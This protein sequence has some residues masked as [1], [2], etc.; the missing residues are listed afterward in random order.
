MPAADQ[1]RESAP[2]PMEASPPKTPPGDPLAHALA[3][4]AGKLG[5]PDFPKGDLADLRRGDRGGPPPPAFWR[6]YLDI[7]ADQ[8]GAWARDEKS[9]RTILQCMAIMAPKAHNP[10]RRLGRVLAELM[11][12]GQ[13][14]SLETRLLKLL[15]S[16][17]R[18]LQEQIRHTARLLASRER[19]VDWTQ[20]ARLVLLDADRRSETVRRDMARDFYIAER[21]N[22][23]EL[24]GPDTPETQG[25]EA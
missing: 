15:S 8:P 10:K 7:A 21:K 25:E 6:L 22:V 3:V 2:R 14:P 19:A 5:H 13:Q 1:P 11:H 24:G 4:L 12:A 16:R 9:W 20:L 23:A 18:L 17:G